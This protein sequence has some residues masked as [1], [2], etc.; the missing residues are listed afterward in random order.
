MPRASPCV[1]RTVMTRA[2]RAV[3][4][5]ILSICLCPIIV[6]PHVIPVVRDKDS[7]AHALH[8]GKLVDKG[9]G[10]I[11][12]PHF[13]VQ[14]NAAGR[15]TLA[16]DD[17]GGGPVLDEAGSPLLSLVAVAVDDKDVGSI[18]V[19]AAGKDKEDQP[20]EHAAEDGERDKP[21]RQHNAR[22]NAPEEESDVH[23]LLDS[24]AEPD[25]G[26]GA[27]HAEREDDIARDSQDKEIG[28]ERKCDQRD[29]KSR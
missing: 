1:N 16:L 22:R 25:N 19:P 26:Q 28:D 13:V 7:V 8:P 5:Q 9:G 6:L 12:K 4:I 29:S 27:H 24:R 14:L 10:A 18:R 23:G 2:D 3:K 11:L 17:S 20:D 21:C 15:N